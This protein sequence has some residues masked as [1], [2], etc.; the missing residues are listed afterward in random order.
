MKPV[1]ETDWFHLL[2]LTY[3]EMLSNFAC[4]GFNLQLEPLRIGAFQRALAIQRK[5]GHTVQ[6]EPKL[7]PTVEPRLA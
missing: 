7:E 4:F 5:V 6:V 1:V 3:D 2:K